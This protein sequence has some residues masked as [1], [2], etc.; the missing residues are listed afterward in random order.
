MPEYLRHIHQIQRAE[1]FQQLKTRSR[2]FYAIKHKMEKYFYVFSL[3]SAM[4]NNA[5]FQIATSPLFEAYEWILSPNVVTTSTLRASR[6]FCFCFLSNQLLIFLILVGKK[7][8]ATQNSQ[9]FKS[10]APLPAYMKVIQGSQWLCDTH[11][12]NG[13]R[14]DIHSNVANALLAPKSLSAF[15]RAQ[16]P[17]NLTKQSPL[18][19]INQEICFRSMFPV[20]PSCQ[21][22]QTFPRTSSSVLKQVPCGRREIVLS[23]SRSSTGW[24]CARFCLVI[25]KSSSVGAVSHFHGYK[26][27]KFIQTQGE[28]WSFIANSL[29]A[30]SST[31]SCLVLHLTPG[32][33]QSSI[34]Q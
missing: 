24:L 22:F 11:T 4:P 27:R 7:K 6:F 34:A 23:K 28:L 19:Q 30:A 1:T 14:K 10:T 8:K 20:L 5:Q 29:L 32:F 9:I 25:L 16:G 31:V 3:G 13:C 17:Q 26:S 2:S 33:S 21:R 15:C 12:Q 18:Y